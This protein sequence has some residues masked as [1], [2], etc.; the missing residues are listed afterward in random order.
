MQ[1][2]SKTVLLTFLMIILGLS[3]AT[4]SLNESTETTML[5]STEEPQEVIRSLSSLNVPGHQE[6]SIYTEATISAGAYNTCAILDNSL[7]TGTASCWGDGDTN[8]LANGGTISTSVPTETDDFGLRSPVSISVGYQHGCAILDDGSVS[9][10]GAGSSGKIGDGLT[11]TMLSPTPTSGFGQGRTAVAIS[12][13]SYHTC[14]ILDT[15]EISCWGYGSEGRNGDGSSSNNLVP[16]ETASLSPRTAI[17]ISA[18]NGH[19]CAILDN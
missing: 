7:Y 15:G 10:W 14:V 19:T 6:G 8:A 17:A 16:S 13:G 1:K 4:N 18:G 12:A 11:N 3:A 9:C 2:I 5:E